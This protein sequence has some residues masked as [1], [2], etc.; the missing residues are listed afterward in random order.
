MLTYVAGR[1]GRLPKSA[2]DH[3]TGPGGRS[4]V[5]VTHERT[6]KPRKDGISIGPSLDTEKG[7]RNA[8]IGPK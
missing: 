5:E 6:Y 4:V 3:V 8:E 2:S 7:G 1:L